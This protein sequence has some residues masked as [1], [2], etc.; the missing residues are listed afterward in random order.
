MQRYWGEDSRFAPENFGNQPIW[1]IMQALEYGQKLTLE[2]L[3]FQEMGTATLSALFVNANRDPKKGQPAKPGDFFYFA[4]AEKENGPKIPAAACDAF[5]SLI[6]EHRLPSWVLD[7]APIEGIRKHKGSGRYP[8]PRAWIG[9]NLLLIL[10]RVEDGMVTAALAFCN[11]AVGGV[12]LHDVDTDTPF[13]LNL[14]KSQ[15]AWSL[16]AEFELICHDH[17]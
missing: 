5:F 9:D 8:K 17:E 7:I 14:P 1:L 16:D 6:T 13:Y 11:G 12:E 15:I 4:S 10:P 2:Q 3:H